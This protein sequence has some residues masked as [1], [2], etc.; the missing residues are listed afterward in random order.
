MRQLQTDRL[1]FR[2]KTM[3]SWQTDFPLADGLFLKYMTR[4][5]RGPPFNISSF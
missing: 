5:T 1:G 4:V 2:L 3:V